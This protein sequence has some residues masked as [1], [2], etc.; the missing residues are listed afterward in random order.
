MSISATMPDLDL[1]ITVDQR[2]AIFA[3][4]RARALD[5][6]DV[7]AM[8]PSGSISKLTR[9]QARDLLDRINANTEYSTARRQNA[10][11]RRPKGV[12]AMVS[13]A[14]RVK[15]KAIQHEIG[16]TDEH[17][18]TWLKQRHHDDG[19]PMTQM[20]S[21]KDAKAVIELL[22]QVAR[23]TA[24]SCNRQLETIPERGGALTPPVISESRSGSIEA[25]S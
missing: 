19:R 25:R 7:R 5:I 12:Y 20:N 17:L 24:K 22:K 9:L 2:R 10:S 18:G 14:Q 8:T 6:D 4:A 15:I 1:P 16:W 23:K 13:E 11:P 21:G 3:A